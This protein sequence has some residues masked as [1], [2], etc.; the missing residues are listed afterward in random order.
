MIDADPIALL[1]AAILL[2]IPALV[3]GMVVLICVVAAKGS[4]RRK[5]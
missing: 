1:F 5:D 2:G 4:G 3:I